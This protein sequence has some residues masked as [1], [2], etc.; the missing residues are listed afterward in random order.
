MESIEEILNQF[1]NVKS[2]L[3][4]KH[5]ELCR[6]KLGLC[7]YQSTLNSVN[8]L[9]KYNNRRIYDLENLEESEFGGKEK[10]DWEEQDA[11]RDKISKNKDEGK[12]NVVNKNI[13]ISHLNL[14]IA[15][16]VSDREE[17]KVKLEKIRG[18]YKE[19]IVERIEALEALLNI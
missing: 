2:L 3:G 13:K 19:R 12:A 1:N 7:H 5:I 17:L 8:K 16:L 15:I 14:E 6:E 18:A 9:A 11:E 10:L 4:N